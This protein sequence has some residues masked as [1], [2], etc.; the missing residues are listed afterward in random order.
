MNPSPSLLPSGFET[1]EP[2]VDFWATDTSAKRAQRRD[3]S[4]EEQRQQFYNAIISLAPTALD[5]LDAKPISEWDDSEKR[6]MQLVLS[7]GHIAMA[8]ELQKDAE[9]E[10]V[11]W[12]PFMHITTTPADR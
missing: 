11:K 3:S 6:L 12:R 9:A 4:T 7:F 1:L 5:Q 10:H 8:V 2:F